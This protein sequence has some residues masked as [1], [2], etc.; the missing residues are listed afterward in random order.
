MDATGGDGCDDG[1]GGVVVV[2]DDD[3]DDG[4]DDDDDDDD[5]DYDNHDEKG[6][7]CW[8]H[9]NGHRYGDGDDNG[10]GDDRVI[11]AR[12]LLPAQIQ[13]RQQ[14][15]HLQRRTSLCPCARCYQRYGAQELLGSEAR[16]RA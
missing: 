10:D 6:G 1:G 2:G 4:D 3:N 16:T 11:I 9:C 15:Q 7:D 5:D 13:L 12:S 14:R 8:S